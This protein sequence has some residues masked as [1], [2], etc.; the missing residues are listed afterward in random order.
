[1]VAMAVRGPP[2]SSSEEAEVLACCKALE[3]AVDASFAELLLEGANVSVMRTISRSRP[4]RSSLRHLYEDIQCLC[5]GLRAM[6]I[7]WVSRTANGV[8]HYL[9]KFAKG[10]VDDVV[11]LEESPPPALEAL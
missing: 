2:V 1:M 10:I 8:A 5:T 3:F 6:S 4:N 7:G 11:W 9:A